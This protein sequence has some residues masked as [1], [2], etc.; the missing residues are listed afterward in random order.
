MSFSYQRKALS[1]SLTATGKQLLPKAGDRWH[2]APLSR[3]F[4]QPRTVP[5]IPQMDLRDQ[6]QLTL[7]DA[8][9]LEREL[10][11][12][13]MSRVFVAEE[14]ALGRKVVV[15]VLPSETA[16]QVS[17]ERF[18]REILLA[19]KL[20]H[21]HIVPL[22]SA[23]ESEGL[24]YFTMP[25]V[26]GESLRARLARHGELPVSDAIRI[27]REIAAAL[28]Y[29]HE[30]GIVHRD[31][32]PDNI[33]LS[34]GSAMVTDFGV[35]KALSASSNADHGGV[36]SLGIA[37]GT[38]AYM[39]PEQA[40]ADP[41][42]DHRA[43]VYAFG[44]L[45]YELLTGQP[46]FVGRTPQNLLAA[47][48]SESA[49]NIGRRR[50]NLPPGLS[51][52]VMRCL[53]KRPADRP[54]SASEIV[55]ALDDITTPSGGMQPTSALLAVP[56]KPAPRVNRS[57]IVAVAVLFIAGT[58]AYW[59]NHRAGSAAATAVASADKNEKRI[60]VMPFGSASRDPADE[61]FADGITDEL[62]AAL[63]KVAGLRLPSRNAVY[64]YHDS[65]L[66]PKV[67][68]TRL[69]V[70][71]ILTGTVRRAGNRLK[72]TAQLLNVADGLST[73]SDSYERDLK[74]VFAV[75]DSIAAAIVGQLKLK[76][77]NGDRPM[78]VAGTQSSKA[79]DLYLQG[80]FYE[81]KYTEPDVRKSIALFEQA[82]AE[83]PKYSAPLAGIARAWLNLADDWAA[84]HDAYPKVFAASRKALAL[85]SANAD[86]LAVLALSE[87]GYARDFA[88][89]ERHFTEALRLEPRNRNVL[90][91]FS[92]LVWRNGLRDSAL[93]LGRRTE[94]SDPINVDG[95]LILQK[96]HAQMGHPDSAEFWIR[97]ALEL[98]PAYVHSHGNV[99]IL[100]MDEGR[101][102]DALAEWKGGSA[103]ESNI[104][105]SMAIC[106][107]HLGRAAD[108]RRRLAALEAKRAKQY[109]AADYIAA[110]YAALG[111]R[112]A[113]FR[114]L[115]K[116]FDERSA[117]I[118]DMTGYEWDPIRADPR[119]QPFQDRINHSVLAH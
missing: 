36:T 70:D 99:A 51:A 86:A 94:E 62:T 48:V 97:R 24:P 14:K 82:S 21:P 16:A 95:P 56:A 49:E 118:S 61:S 80:M 34:G 50:S 17:L 20:Q 72:V 116:A 5:S 35:A 6:L 44:V 77:V 55:H 106:E 64:V 22:L 100:R 23:G 73:W 53:E 59:M 41:A 29:A 26:E 42:I 67:I 90:N 3:S 119:F 114:W 101:W 89:S 28:A 71:A 31:I 40:T 75:E 54:Q 33:L 10:G 79:H 93:A 15:K 87:M 112:D 78:V 39:A 83:D 98:N 66:D 102:A 111:D 96:F 19:A 117:F 65:T 115:D 18:K 108:A 74:D 57:T 43:D 76:L 105:S 2:L 69:G 52:L 12:G 92:Q 30:R 37:L 9:T 4:F 13:G 25:F 47:H 103:F 58:F 107:A 109:V 88:S 27:L 8:Y 81:L 68:G 38:P 104:E 113:A 11:G 7:G 32:K 84:P 1:F 110:V 46:P 91:W 45:A 60:A 85:D 63:G